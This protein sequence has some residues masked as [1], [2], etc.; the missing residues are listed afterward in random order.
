L[1]HL[2]CIVACPTGGGTAGEFLVLFAHSLEKQEAVWTLGEENSGVGRSRVLLLAF[3]LL[4]WRHYCCEVGNK[5]R[6]F[7]GFEEGRAQ[8]SLTAACGSIETMRDDNLNK[9]VMMFQVDSCTV[10]NDVSVSTPDLV[11]GCG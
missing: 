5:S 7:G 10:L 6:D 3:P 8:S 4:D 2:T 11:F 1:G 9:K